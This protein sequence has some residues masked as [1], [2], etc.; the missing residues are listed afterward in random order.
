MVDDLARRRPVF[1]TAEERALI[2]AETYEPGA[3]VAGVA[4][5]HAIV[6]SQLSSWRTAAKNKAERGEYHVPEFAS[7]S[8][9]EDAPVTPVENIEVVYGKVLIR[10]PK[11]TASKRIADIALCLE[12]G[13]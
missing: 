9:M 8:V 1:R 7:I 5:R 13:P 3:T 11:C 6:A 2:V 4:S 10:L 12:Q